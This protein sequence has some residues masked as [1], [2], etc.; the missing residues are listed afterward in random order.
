MKSRHDFALMREKTMSKTFCNT[1][2]DRL[3]NINELT[4]CIDYNHDV[5]GVGTLIVCYVLNTLI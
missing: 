1:S 2:A 4:V 3:P 5:I